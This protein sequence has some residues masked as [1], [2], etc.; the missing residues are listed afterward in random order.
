MHHYHYHKLIMIYPSFKGLHTKDTISIDNRRN[1]GHQLKIKLR[2][3]LTCR[4]LKQLL[5]CPLNSLRTNLRTVYKCIVHLAQKFHSLAK[6]LPRSK[7]WSCLVLTVQ[8]DFSCPAVWWR[9]LLCQIQKRTVIIGLWSVQRCLHFTLSPW[10]KKI[11]STD[12]FYS[13]STWI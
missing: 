13:C 5:N 12:V 1:K 11:C 3:A 4:S 6:A 8:H 10:S 2:R 7:S 9:L